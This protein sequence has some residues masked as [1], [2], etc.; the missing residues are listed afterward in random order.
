MVVQCDTQ[1]IEIDC[2]E[3]PVRVELENPQMVGTRLS[4]AGYAG[5]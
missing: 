5:G 2:R 4:G 3:N 1:I